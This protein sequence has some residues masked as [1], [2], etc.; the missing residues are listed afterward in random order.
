[1]A[2]VS[3]MMEP[4]PP[5]FF[6]ELERGGDSGCV[7]LSGTYGQELL[8]RY[9]EEVE[10]AREAELRQLIVDLRSLDRVDAVALEA[11]L[12]RWISKRQDGVRLIL[13][14]VP[15]R[16]RELMEETGFDRQL[17]IYYEGRPING[18]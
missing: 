12:G 10:A 7:R 1:M 16:M 17:P 3:E 4:P 18:H 11:L 14:R 13:V 2:V 5:S 6:V 8:Q 9:E 15:K